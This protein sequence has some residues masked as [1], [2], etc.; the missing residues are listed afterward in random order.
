MS[1]RAGGTPTVSPGLTDG[2]ASRSVDDCISTRD[3]E[4]RPSIPKSAYASSGTYPVVDQG[5]S[6]IAGFTNDETAIHRG[7]LPLILFGDHTRAVKYIDFP[8]ATGADGT[9][10]MHAVSGVDSRYLY[11][12]LLNRKLPSRG[13]NRHFGLL[14]QETVDVPAD[15]TEQRAIADVSSKLQIAVELQDRIVAT[16]KELK[17]A[18]MAKLFREGLLGEP[19]KQTEIGEIPE[20]WDV[21]RL[22]SLIDPVSGGTPSKRRPDWWQGSIPW[23]SP[24]DMK[25]TRLVDTEDHISAEALS[26]GSR[27]VPAKTIFVVTRGMVLAKDVPVAITEAP[28][29]FN[30]DMRA[31]LPTGAIDPDF[32]LYAIIA[33]KNALRP[34]IGT[35]AHG[36]RRLGAPS[37]EELLLPKPKHWDEQEKIAYALRDLERRI[38][39][40][41]KSAVGR[42]LL[43]AEML[44]QLVTGRLRV[45]RGVRR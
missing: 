34:S 8:F 16:L 4:R 20:S 23:A 42:R 38:V 12:A 21:V 1:E 19:L 6:L 36:T 11:F 7:D 33:R 13:Y 25:T 18:T 35:S 10:L 9:K 29:A 32:L 30:Q 40:G 22:D 15:E 31:L 2:W 24:K 45:M 14:C 26:Q 27:L 44:S 3:F 39:V 43:F 37:V 41:Q 28:M 5:Q 17:A